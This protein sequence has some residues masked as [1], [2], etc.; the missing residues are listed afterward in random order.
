[1]HLLSSALSI[2][3]ILGSIVRSVDGTP[4]PV[5]RRG[6]PPITQE[7]I[8]QEDYPS[9]HEQAG[10]PSIK[11]EGS[12]S[13]AHGDSAGPMVS[14][15]HPASY[16][17]NQP[18]ASHLNAQGGF[19][20]DAGPAVSHSYGH[21]NSY[22]PGQGVGTHDRFA[23]GSGNRYRLL[24][25]KPALENPAMPY[26]PA[27]P[28]H[29]PAAPGHSTAS[30]SAGLNYILTV[31]TRGEP[32]RSDIERLFVWLGERIMNEWEGASKER[33]F[34]IVSANNGVHSYL[35]HFTLQAAPGT[36]SVTCPHE[37]PC[38]GI[39]I[40]QPGMKWDCRIT[41]AAKEHPITISYDPGNTWIL[42]TDHTRVPG[43]IKPLLESVASIALSNWDGVLF[44]HPKVL[45]KDSTHD[46]PPFRN[47]G[48][49]FQIVGSQACL[50]YNP[51]SGL[52]H[53]DL[54]LIT[55]L[56]RGTILIGG[57]PPQ[58]LRQGA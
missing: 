9:P 37:K 23:G 38:V 26:Y 36:T 12:S 55:S 29:G 45:N 11:Q 14:P 22:G 13:H 32:I 16:G 19:S 49:R 31:E 24:A 5:D 33:K 20:E 53:R 18:G 10:S 1:M 40:H 25:P 39:T 27:I 57:E 52:F 42:V 35:D 3:L 6:S 4:V 50:P 44:E 15:Y 7:S 48:F 43:N 54:W 47:D 51:C 41:S 2:S 8:K 34:H 21:A 46:D 30:S 17:Y 56:S 28:E 58:V